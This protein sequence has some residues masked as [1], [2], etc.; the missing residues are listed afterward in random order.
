MEGQQQLEEKI[1]T[2]ANMP[3][4]RVSDIKDTNT[5]EIALHAV[6]AA[7][8][9]AETRLKILAIASSTS[10]TEKVEWLKE[11]VFKVKERTGRMPRGGWLVVTELLNQKFNLS[12]TVEGTKTLASKPAKETSVTGKRKATCASQLDGHRISVVSCDPHHLNQV[13]QVLYACMEKCKIQPMDERTCARKV[14][15]KKVDNDVI[16]GLNRVLTQILVENPPKDFE[17]LSSLYYSAQ[18]AYRELTSK[19]RKPSTWGANIE[20]KMAM[21]AKQV[22]LLTNHRA[23]LEGKYSLGMTSQLKK[24]LKSAKVDKGSMNGIVRLQQQKMD[25]FKIY[26]KKIRWHESRKAFRRE[27]NQFE[28]NRRMFYRKLTEGQ[29]MAGKQ[30]AT[31]MASFWGKMWKSEPGSADFDALV[32]EEPLKYGEEQGIINLEEKLVKLIERLPN[33]KTPG[34]DKVSNFFIKKLTV[35][36]KPLIRLVEKAIACP[37]ECPKWFFSGVTYLIPKVASP[38]DPS[39]YRP[40]TCMSNLYKLVTKLVAQEMRSIVKLNGILSENQLGTRRECQGAKEQ[41]LINKRVNTEHK[42][43]LKSIWIDIKKAYDSVNHD[44]LKKCIRKLGMPDWC[45]NFVDFI[46]DNWS[47]QLSYNQKVIGKVDLGRVILQGDSL[48]PLLFVLCME[49][50]SRVINATFPALPIEA[51]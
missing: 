35:L 43:L 19:K 23:D 32:K 31:E 45:T 18:M 38:E 1:S 36:H 33:W 26:E 37:G 20:S 21:L 51:G 48:S 13:Q 46:V 4:K 42:F 39:E 16:A 22:R 44:Y 25:L 41:A 24:L 5:A 6:P 28:Y 47:I 8:P 3:K 11:V 30:A 10:S 14:P 9:V 7:G 50:L 34:V 12:L 49:P 17:D 29:K 2:K 27:N 15:E 40:I